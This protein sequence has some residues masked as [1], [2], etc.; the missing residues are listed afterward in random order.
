MATDYQAIFIRQV[1]ARSAENARVF[2][3]LARI[4]APGQMI[5][6]LRQELDSIIR[7]LYLFQQPKSR[8]TELIK[9]SVNGVRWRRADST[10][11]VTDR[12]MLELSSKLM[13]YDKYV[14]KFGCH[15]RPSVHAC[16]PLVVVVMLGKLALVPSVPVLAGLLL[17]KS[18]PSNRL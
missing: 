15:L 4:N 13:G 10:A 2:K 12:E 6:V 16:A 17:L 5:A 14:Y 9:E 7:V 3:E 1:R 11:F 18:L 8:R